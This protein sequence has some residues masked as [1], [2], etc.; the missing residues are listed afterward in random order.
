[1]AE[2]GQLRPIV[3][4]GATGSKAPFPAIRRLTN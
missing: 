4:P 2:K 1:M 3:A